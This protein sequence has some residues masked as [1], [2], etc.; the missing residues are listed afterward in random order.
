[1]GKGYNPRPQSVC[2]GSTHHQLGCLSPRSSCESLITHEPMCEQ[3]LFPAEGFQYSIVCGRQLMS[4]PPPLLSDGCTSLT[5]YRW[6]PSLLFHILYPPCPT[7]AH[8]HFQRTVPSFFISKYLHVILCCL[9]LDKTTNA[10]RLAAF[11]MC[12]VMESESEISIMMV[13]ITGSESASSF[14]AYV[15]V[16]LKISCCHKRFC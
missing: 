15:F 9:M 1:M 7:H 16:S 2:L 11:Q 6:P 5:Y 10:S 8:C 12:A 3:W 4:K 14:F 13:A